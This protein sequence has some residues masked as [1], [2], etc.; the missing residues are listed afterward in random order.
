M[1]SEKSSNQSVWSM[2]NHKLFISG[3]VCLLLLI[4]TG[5][6]FPKAFTDGMNELNTLFMSNFKWVY[7]LCAVATSFFC[8]W[9]LFSKYGNIRFGGKNA[10]PSI[11][12]ISW[13]TISLTGSIAIGIC[14]FG[15]AGPVNNF[16]NPPA[17]AGVKGGT[18]D[19]IIPSIMYCF[20][21]YGIPAY[22]IVTFSGFA[23]A[24]LSYNGKRPF[25]ASSTLYPLIGDR[26]DGIIGSIVD[27]VMVLSL[28]IV[29]TNMGLSVI[30]LNAGI[31]SILGGTVFDFQMI[32][33]VVYVL[34]VIYFACSG[35]HGSMAKLANINTLFYVGVILFV[36]F[37]GGVNRLLG[38]YMTSVTEFIVQYI[39]LTGFAD[40]ILQSGWQESNSM[41]FYSWNAMPGLLAA[42][43]YA[44]VSYGRTLREF[45][46]VNV[47]VPTLFMTFWYVFIGG[48]AMFGVLEGSNLPQVIAE[49]GSGIATFAFLDTLPFGEITKW[50]FIFMAVMTF[51][52]WGDAIC[53]SF[54]LMFMKRTEKDAANTN[55]PKVLV[56]GTAVFMG[57]LTMTLVFVGGYTAMETWILV[58]GLPSSLLLVIM[59]I[60]CI[61]FLCQREKYDLVYM[62]EKNQ[63]KE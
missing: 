48:T 53:Y 10:I 37:N 28:V 3:T 5:M 57:L 19:A 61:K 55:T 45:I 17:F 11:K 31:N 38:L 14:F 30:Q 43:F 40:P 33:I 29:G 34:A 44:S 54:P 7:V 36:L 18:L 49:K 39:P 41:F 8:I 24:L 59:V 32:I 50:V 6:L 1:S 47:L 22:F 9:L 51:V 23:I 21:H 12:T 4:L 58:W 52:T 15:V 2:I 26:C 56:A 13:I 20:L 62:E 60:S 16:M 63:E 42:F 27:T 46:L 35:V 25:R